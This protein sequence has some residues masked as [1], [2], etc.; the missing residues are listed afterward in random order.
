LCASILVSIGERNLTAEL[1]TRTGN[2]RWIDTSIIVGA[3]VFMLALAVSAIFAPQWRALHVAQALPYIVIIVL[4]R[5]GNPWGFGAGVITASF[6]N[7]LLLFRSPVG[8]ALAHGDVSRPDVAIQLLAALGHFMIIGACLVGFW[9]TRP[10][11]RQWASFFGGGAIAVGY[12]LVMV[13]TVGPAEGVAHIK[14][15]L[16][17]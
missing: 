5:R 1:D 14:Q 9:R 11:G 12:L 15:A 6:W 7:W 2:A 17:L 13:W 10:A 3:V 4:T 8:I 16:G